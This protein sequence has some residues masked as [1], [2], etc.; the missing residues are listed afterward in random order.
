[1]KR[2]AASTSAAAGGSSLAELRVGRS[3]VAHYRGPDRPGRLVRNE[4]TRIL[5]ARI[6]CITDI[7][8]GMRIHRTDVHVAPAKA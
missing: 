1:M 4:F 6:L 5:L 3:G 2:S 8:R 7:S